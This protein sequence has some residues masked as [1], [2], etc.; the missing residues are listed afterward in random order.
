M[1]KHSFHSPQKNHTELFLPF[2]FE[3]VLLTIPLFFFFQ[4]FVFFFLLL[5]EKQVGVGGRKEVRRG[6]CV[7]KI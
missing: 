1:Y 5:K 2:P 6:K 7:F 4:S 3:L